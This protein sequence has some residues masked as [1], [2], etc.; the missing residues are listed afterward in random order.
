MILEE[1]NHLFPLAKSASEAVNTSYELRSKEWAVK[2]QVA[3]P[4]VNG[5][6][7]LDLLLSWVQVLTCMLLRTFISESISTKLH[8][9]RSL[10]VLV[11]SQIYV[12]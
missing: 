6:A 9:S 5:Y 7:M 12:I 2:L 4:D 1:Y 3:N 11:D 10:V 8:R